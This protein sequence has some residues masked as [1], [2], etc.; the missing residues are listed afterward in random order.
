M[1]PTCNEQMNFTTL[2]TDIQ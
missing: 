2:C 1:A